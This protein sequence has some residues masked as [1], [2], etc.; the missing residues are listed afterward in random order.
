LSGRCP[1]LCAADPV[2]LRITQTYY[3][4]TM[5]NFGC[6]PSQTR[7]IELSN[8]RTTELTRPEAGQEIA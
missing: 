8:R 4:I 6:G 1:T 7:M 2:I 3:K 5:N